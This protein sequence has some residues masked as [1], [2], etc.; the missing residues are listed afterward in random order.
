MR[1]QG[2]QELH[3]FSRNFRG[4]QDL[5]GFEDVP[6]GPKIVQGGFRRVQSIS[7]TIQRHSVRG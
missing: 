5:D 2:L 6:V 1:F 3:V 7:A 4:F